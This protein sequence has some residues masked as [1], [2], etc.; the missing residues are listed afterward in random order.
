MGSLLAV[1]L[2]WF[3]VPVLAQI[4]VWCAGLPGCGD[5]PSN[6]IATNTLPGIILILATLSA[7]ATVVFVV[8]A[9]IQLVMMYGD[10]GKASTAKNTVLYALGGLALSIMASSIVSFVATENYIAGSGNIIIAFMQSVVRIM[11]TVFNTL[12]LAA[13]V[14]AGLRFVLAG[15]KTDE[16]NKAV[17]I[18]KWA[19]FG[20]IIV[21]VGRALVEALMRTFLL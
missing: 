9:G 19:I 4:N 21:N 12:F 8:Y 15:G 14:L 7:G 20:A 13:I 16:F 10:E 11:L 5:G 3:P 18:I 1:L 2:L 17:G 6:V